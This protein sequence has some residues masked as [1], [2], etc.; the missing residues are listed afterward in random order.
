MS[1]P[2]SALL[3]VGGGALFWAH[4]VSAPAITIAKTPSEPWYTRST[5]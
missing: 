1:S 5:L 4:A 2:E 3:T